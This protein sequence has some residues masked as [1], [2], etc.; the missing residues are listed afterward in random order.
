MPAQRDYYEVL[1]VSREASADE[2]KKAYRK[3]A[4]KHHPDRNPG[5]A[6]AVA[7]FKEASEAFDVLSNPEKRAR[8][9]RFGHAGVQGAAGGNGGGFND[10]QDIF[11]AFGDLFGD[12]FGGGRRSGGG[13]RARRGDSLKTTV[14]VTLQEAAAGCRRELEIERHQTCVACTGSGAKAGTTPKTCEYCGGAG[15]VVQS[16]G[17][18]RMQTTCPACRGQ[19]KVVKDKC[20][21]CRGSGAVPHAS[22]LEVRIPAGIDNGLQL[23]LRGEGETGEN[24][25]PPGD[26]YVEVRVQPHAMFQRRGRDLVCVVPVTYSQAALG[27]DIEIPLLDGRHQLK[28]PAGTQPMEVLRLR[29]LGMPDLQGSGRGDLLVEIH[30]EVPKKLSKPQEDLIRQ[31]AELDA[32]HVSS[33]R[34]SFFDSLK[35]YFAGEET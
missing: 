33:K 15:Q 25:G 14:T 4:L 31:L 21:D 29:Q 12:M 5:D 10:V 11:D 1:G 34:K 9:D 32:K 19:G 26:L 24:G 28:I 22:K 18:F 2:L 3:L 7:K 30:V 6:E 13:P 16:Q 8:Y 17:F 27:A 20:V 35:E 23:C